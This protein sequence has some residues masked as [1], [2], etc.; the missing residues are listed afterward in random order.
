M[1]FLTI[2]TLRFSK[3][4]NRDPTCARELASVQQAFKQPHGVNNVCPNK[5][6]TKT[7]IVTLCFERSGA[8]ARDRLCRMPAR[9]DYLLIGFAVVG[10]M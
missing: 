6:H 2:P 5:H 7:I 1:K 8:R 9:V 3:L 4:T 10:A